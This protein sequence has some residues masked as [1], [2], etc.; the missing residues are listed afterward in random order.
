MAETVDAL[1]WRVF[2][3]VD[4]KTY[5]YLLDL[6]RLHRVDLIDLVSYLLSA[7]LALSADDLRVV[8]EREIPPVLN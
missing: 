7:G 2:G 4:S 1:R 8:A 6:C 3:S 5:R